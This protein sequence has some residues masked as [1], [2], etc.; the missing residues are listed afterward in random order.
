MGSA[1]LSANYYSN[2]SIDRQKR[3]GILA[4]VRFSGLKPGR[5]R[6]VFETEGFP[7]LEKPF[8]VKPGE[9]VEVRAEFP[10]RGQ[11][12]VQ[13]NYEARDAEIRLD[14]EP[15]GRAPIKKTVRAGAHKIEAILPGF[16]T[17]TKTITVPEEDR[18][19]L[20]IAM[21]KSAA[22]ATPPASGQ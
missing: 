13:V 14:G 11:L 4:G 17:V 5:H 22:P 3:Q 1:V 12:Q 6:A 9:A 10:P 18:Y 8:D 7:P 15:I 20:K 2:V 21:K 16:E 19:D